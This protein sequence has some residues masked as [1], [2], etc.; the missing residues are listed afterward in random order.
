MTTVTK[1]IATRVTARMFA[2]VL[3]L[4]GTAW[5]VTISPKNP[6]QF[7]DAA[8]RDRSAVISIV[9]E[10]EEGRAD[11]RAILYTQLFEIR[12]DMER[13]ALIF[14]MTSDPAQV[15][16]ERSSIIRG[17][18]DASPETDK[19]LAQADSTY[20]SLQAQFEQ[21]RA[22]LKESRSAA[23]VDT[24]PRGDSAGDPRLRRR[25]FEEEMDRWFFRRFQAN[26]FW[27]EW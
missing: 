2:W 9:K 7:F 21:L 23:A 8:H 12:R 27:R 26:I 22:E 25:L 3:L 19:A 20:R 4:L 11:H 15:R 17:F 5:F 1:K 10:S 14:D 16:R 24:D 18:Y 6:I 13:I